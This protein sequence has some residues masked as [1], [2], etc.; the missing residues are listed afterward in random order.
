[1]SGGGS[2]FGPSF[3]PQRFAPP[4]PGQGPGRPGSTRPPASGFAA[5]RQVGIQAVALVSGFVLVLW[6][7]E[8]YDAVDPRNLDQA[9]IQPREADGLWGILWAPLLH[10]GWDHLISNTVPVFVLGFLVLVA[11]I[12]RGLAATAIIWV[13]AGVGTWLTGGEGTVHIGASALVFGWLTFLILRGWFARSAWQILLGMAVLVF[14]GSLLWGVLPGQDGI[15]WQGHL[16]GAIGGVVA[17]WAP[18]RGARAAEQ[19]AS[20]RTRF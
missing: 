12:G 1:M 3:D 5:V 20:S 17:A 14:Y 9:G 4:R 13:I 18:Y 11:G 10:N 8:G 7:V 6:G 19:P 2:G 16:F 15:S